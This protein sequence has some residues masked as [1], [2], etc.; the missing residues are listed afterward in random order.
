MD[1]GIPLRLAGI[2]RFGA[3]S[4]KFGADLDTER[5][6]ASGPHH[7]GGVSLAGPG[8]SFAA[9]GLQGGVRP[10]LRITLRHVGLSYARPVCG[11]RAAI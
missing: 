9:V 11:A 7:P 5:S 10:V 6:H 4:A 3:E 8:H 1:R 2:T